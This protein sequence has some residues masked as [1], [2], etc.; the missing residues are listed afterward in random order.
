[1]VLPGYLRVNSY[2]Q[3]YYVIKK[4]KFMTIYLN[5]GFIILVLRGA[6]S[7]KFVLLISESLFTHGKSFK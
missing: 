1:M 4:I 7:L 3:E 2:S 6:V 5:A